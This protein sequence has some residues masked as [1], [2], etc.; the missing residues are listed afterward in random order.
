MKEFFKDTEVKQFT[1]NEKLHCVFKQLIAILNPTILSENKISY[2]TYGGHSKLKNKIEKYPLV[3]IDPNNIKMAQMLEM[4]F[5]E[6]ISLSIDK[7]K[8]SISGNDFCY[9]FPTDQILLIWNRSK[10]AGILK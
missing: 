5:K 6:D 9:E 7:E 8:I 3:S 4:P 1:F 2:T 10:K